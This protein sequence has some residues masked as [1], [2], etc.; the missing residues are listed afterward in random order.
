MLVPA[1]FIWLEK[2]TK[3]AIFDYFPPIIWIFL[4]PIVFSSL[5]IIPSSSPVYGSFKKIAVPLFIILMLLD[6]DIKRSIKVAGKSVFIV[7]FGAFGVVVGAAIAFAL[8]KSGLP[9]DA[10]RGFGALAGSWIG[11]TGN[12]AAVAESINTPSEMMGIVVLADTIIYIIW[13]PVML[14]CKKWAKQYNK[15][16]GI[17]EDEEKNQALELSEYKEKSKEVSFYNL[18]VLIGFALLF[19]Y[20]ARAIAS[21][22]P[23]LGLINPEKKAENKT[24]KKLES[25]EKKAP[26]KTVKKEQVQKKEQ[27]SKKPKKKY[28]I[29]SQKTWAM[30]LITTFGIILS[31]TPLRKV[32]GTG[33]VA[34]ALVYTYMSMIAAECDVRKLVEAPL[35]LL[36]SLIC[37][38]LHG[39]FC[40]IGAKLLKVDVHLTA[41]ASA[42]NIGGAASAPV[43]AAYHNKNLVPIAI[44]FALIGYALGNYLGFLTFWMCSII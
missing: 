18:I 26:E 34:M 8:F 7:V 37:I 24:P 28:Y 32:P 17:T 16:V 2:K 11:G 23:P 6:V 4:F 41:I 12:M 1:F 27:K 20:I 36:A 19:I 22:L 5:S 39:L 9:E 30:L 14:G 15:F 31:M 35:F 44:I 33:A 38:I 43:V 29:V 40:V 3:W 21:E 25:K 10:P 13:F 42:A